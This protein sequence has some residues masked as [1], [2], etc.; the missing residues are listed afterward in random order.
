MLSASGVTS[1]AYSMTLAYLSQM[2]GDKRLKSF[3]PPPPALPWLHSGPSP[4]PGHA[5]VQT[6]QLIMSH[7]SSLF[8]FYLFLPF[9]LLPHLAHCLFPLRSREKGKS[10]CCLAVCP[11]ILFFS[12]PFFFSPSSPSSHLWSAFRS[13]FTFPS[14][15]PLC[16]PL[17]P[18]LSPPAPNHS[19]SISCSH[20]FP[21][22]PLPPSLSSPPQ[23]G[24]GAV[25]RCCLLLI[26]VRSD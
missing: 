26:W 5:A 17:S 11:L 7:T 8:F 14:S 23:L 9:L 6:F 2:L 1:R 18:S 25:N 13:S 22:S 21:S 16:F 19:P 3:S 12:S 20:S 24:S 10:V 4:L 15:F